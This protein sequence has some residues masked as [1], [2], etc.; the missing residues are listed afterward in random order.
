M[1][2]GDCRHFKGLGIWIYG[3]CEK[4]GRFRKTTDPPCAFFEPRNERKEERGENI[5]RG[6]QVPAL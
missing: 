5:G 2:C 6:Q 4:L 3:Y 1:R